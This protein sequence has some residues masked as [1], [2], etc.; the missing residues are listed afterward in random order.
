MGSREDSPRSLSDWY[1]GAVLGN[2]SVPAPAIIGEI[3]INNQQRYMH[4][5]V[6]NLPSC[7]RFNKEID[8]PNVPL[9]D[10]VLG[11][12]S[13][14]QKGESDNLRVAVSPSAKADGETEDCPSSGVA[15]VNKISP[16]SGV[17]EE[18]ASLGGDSSRLHAVS[19]GGGSGDIVRRKLQAGLGWRVSSNAVPGRGSICQSP[20][21]FLRVSR[22]G[23]NN[24]R[25]RRWVRL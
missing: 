20:H 14:E 22:S 2:D 8:Q 16:L 1:K 15:K 3:R 5:L 11:E 10:E 12:T 4:W 7:R 9:P 17:V 18:R 13:D 25:F 21:V 24:R 6:Y 19:L 23:G